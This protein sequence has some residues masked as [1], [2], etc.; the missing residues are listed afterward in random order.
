MPSNSLYVSGPALLSE[1]VHNY[2]G[3]DVFFT[4]LDT[5]GAQWPYTGMRTRERLLAFERPNE[6]RHWKGK[7]DDDYAQRH[8]NKDVY[9]KNCTIPAEPPPVWH[10]SSDKARPMPQPPKQR[11]VPKQG[12]VL[13]RGHY[14]RVP[15]ASP[16]VPFSALPQWAMNRYAVYPP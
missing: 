5:R 12:W 9:A 2:T 8:K 11:T 10:V 3:K 1:C 7:D 6:K 16:K 15:F 13:G 4:H 14:G